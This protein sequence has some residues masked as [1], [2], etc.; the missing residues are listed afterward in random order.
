MA[1]KWV[2][3]KFMKKNEEDI[4][5]FFLSF[6]IL[7]LWA[8][9][10]NLDYRTDSMGD[11]LAVHW[12]AGTWGGVKVQCSLHGSTCN[13][14]LVKHPWL[15]NNMNICCSCLNHF[16]SG[17]CHD[18]IDL[19][20]KT[21]WKC[22]CQIEKCLKAAVS[23]FVNQTIKKKE[24]WRLWGFRPSAERIKMQISDF[25]IKVFTVALP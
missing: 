17:T 25:L 2:T 9:S 12:K 16:R 14:R 13:P 21:M 6:V 8:F 5:F 22:R 3:F 18:H 23:C 10:P 15:L 20:V 11:L 4:N 7:K 24:E 1:N 19:W